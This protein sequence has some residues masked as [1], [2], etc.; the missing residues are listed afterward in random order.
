MPYR[1]YDPDVPLFSACPC[2]GDH[3]AE[4]H[5]ESSNAPVSGPAEHSTRTFLEA[6]L[7]KA[8]FPQEASRRRFLRSVGSTAAMGVIA[9]L[10]PLDALEALAVEPAGAL[11][12]KDLKIGFIAITCAAPLI[13][14]DPLGFYK[15]QGLNVTLN[16]TAG[17]AL[18]R[19]K[20]LNHEHDASHFLAP[21][22]LAL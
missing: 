16:K 22:P 9:S 12:K 11:E 20:M 19:D 8:L 6:V 10:F 21:M 1:P 14:A 18:I 13:M 5:P 3:N 7:L 2:G 17:W 15:Q 4:S